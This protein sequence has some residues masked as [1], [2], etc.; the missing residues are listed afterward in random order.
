[1]PHT[2]LREAAPTAAPFSTRGC[3]NDYAQDKLS[4]SALCPMPHAPCPI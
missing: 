3:A 2:Y 1:M 4:T